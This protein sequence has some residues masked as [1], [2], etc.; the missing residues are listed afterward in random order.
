M[1]SDAAYRS[2]DFL[3]NFCIYALLLGGALIFAWSFL[4]MATTSVKVTLTQKQRLPA[5]LWLVIPLG[6]SRTGNISSA[7]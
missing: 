1:K 5:D 2:Q 6:I 7:A 3:R 4:C